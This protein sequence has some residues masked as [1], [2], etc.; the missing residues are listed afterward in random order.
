MI[1]KNLD[2]EVPGAGQIF[3]QENR[4]IAKSRA[5]LALR[6]F[7]QRIELRGILDHAHS[8]SAAAHRGFYDDRVTDFPRNLLRL[9]GRLHRLFGSRQD[10]HTR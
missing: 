5:R 4:G 8:P 7:E 10:R 3:F 6:F 2:L 9:H 1:G